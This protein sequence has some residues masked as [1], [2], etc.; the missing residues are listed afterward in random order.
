[1]EKPVDVLII[2]AALGEDDAVREVEDGGLGPW[3]EA[4]GPEGY[5][6]KVWFGE[7]QTDSGKPMRIALTRAYQMGTDSAVSAASLLTK[8]YSPRCLAM[9]GV[10]AGRPER[11]NLGDVI[12]ADRVYR[13]DT[14]EEVN[15]LPGAKPVF[16]CRSY[17]V[18]FQS[19]MDTGRPTV[20]R[21]P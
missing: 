7:F 3:E 19:T 2:T 15:S 13:Y 9:C 8:A 10:C 12:I 16:S 11:T 5:G 14:G 18:P 4:P 6:F 17:D 1:M 20:C 21:A